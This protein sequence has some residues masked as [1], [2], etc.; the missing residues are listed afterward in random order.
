MAPI[1]STPVKNAFVRC[2][3]G[4]LAPP[5][6]SLFTSPRLAQG[7]AIGM[8]DPPESD[9]W[10]EPRC[11]GGRRRDHGDRLRVECEDS[12]ERRCHLPDHAERRPGVEGAAGAHRSEHIPYVGGL[13]LTIAGREA[14]CNYAASAIHAFSAARLL[15]HAFATIDLTTHTAPSLAALR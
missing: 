13:G 5:C 9:S 8:E 1:P 10:P 2:S 14:N 3:G 15:H 4:T 6:Y 11:V 12:S 7:D